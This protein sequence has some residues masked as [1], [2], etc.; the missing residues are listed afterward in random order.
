MKKVL[1]EELKHTFIR[2]YEVPEIVCDNLIDFFNTSNLKTEGVINFQGK[3][4]VDKSYKESEDIC[5]DQQAADQYPPILTYVEYLES[6]CS[7]YVQS[8][9]SYCLNKEHCLQLYES[10]NLQ[11][12]PAGGGYKKWHCERNGAFEEPVKRR[13]LVFMTYLNT[14]ND[15]EPLD[16]G[17]EFLYQDIKIKAVKGLTLIWPAEWMYTHRG[18]IAP[19]QVKYIATGWFSIRELN[20]DE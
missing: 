11:R 5:I 15:I 17:T 8:E 20:Y 3:I 12:Y 16:G 7:D 9:F 19:T 18:I 14:V 1:E 6:F 13:H 10:I 2:G 4:K